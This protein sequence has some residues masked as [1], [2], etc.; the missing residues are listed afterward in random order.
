MK[1]ILFKIE[2]NVN[3]LYYE[4]YDRLLRKCLVGYQPLYPA[5]TQ[6]ILRL[7]TALILSSWLVSYIDQLDYPDKIFPVRLFLLV[8]VQLYRHLFV[9]PG[10]DPR[11]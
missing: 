6:L 1:N 11:I 8:Y 7:I 5:S 9:L 2:I 3:T 4:I 10:L